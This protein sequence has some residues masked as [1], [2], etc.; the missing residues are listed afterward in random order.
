ME[1]ACGVSPGDSHQDQDQLK[2]GL[3][4]FFSAGRHMLRLSL[5]LYSPRNTASPADRDM[6]NY[7]RGE[8]VQCLPCIFLLR[9]WGHLHFGFCVDIQTLKVKVQNFF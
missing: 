2:F 4:M 3:I 5:M 6:S 1:I 7:S 9:A 8:M